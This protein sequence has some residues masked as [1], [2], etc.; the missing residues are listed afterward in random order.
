MQGTFNPKVLGS[1]PSGAIIYQDDMND[2][3]LLK[4]I[5]KFPG[6][7]EESIDIICD[8]YC[9]DFIRAHRVVENEHGPIFHNNT[10]LLK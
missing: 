8:I 7:F 6:T 10:P 4:A 5:E 3:Q 1:S 2:K 9:I